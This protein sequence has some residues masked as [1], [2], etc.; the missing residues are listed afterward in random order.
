MR[1]AL[2]YAETLIIAY[3]LWELKSRRVSGPPLVARLTN[4]APTPHTAISPRLQRHERLDIY[5][6][7]RGLLQQRP[8]RPPNIS[9][10]PP[11]QLLL[12]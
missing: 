8:G 4:A 1:Y 7:H 9:V 5:S 2:L 6:Y 3:I 10:S 11:S 12:Y